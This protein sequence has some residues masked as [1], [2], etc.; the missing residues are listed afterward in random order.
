MKKLFYYLIIRLTTRHAINASKIYETIYHTDTN[1]TVVTINGY[2]PTITD[3]GMVRGKKQEITDNINYIKSK[4]KK[5]KQDKESLY[6]LEMVLK[7][8]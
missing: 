6:A 5:T 7:N 8:M 3:H 1:E 4:N 2:T